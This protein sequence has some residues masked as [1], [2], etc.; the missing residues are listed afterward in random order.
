MPPSKQGDGTKLAV[1]KAEVPNRVR[2]GIQAMSL[3]MCQIPGILDE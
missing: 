1:L 2:D 3:S